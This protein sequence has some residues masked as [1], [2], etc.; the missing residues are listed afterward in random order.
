MASANSFDIGAQ[1]TCP[2]PENVFLSTDTL[3]YGATNF[4][5][6]L[7]A[8]SSIITSVTV[9]SWRYK[10]NG[11]S[12]WVTMGTSFF[13]NSGSTPGGY[14]NTS[15]SPTVTT[16]VIVEILSISPTSSGYQTY[17]F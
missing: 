10:I 15:T 17:S 6:R 8:A 11:G 9:T 12:T 3:T 1:I 4:Q 7:K 5:V 2:V 13:M 16:S 14:I